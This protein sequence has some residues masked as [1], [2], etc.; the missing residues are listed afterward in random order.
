[1]LDSIALLATSSYSLSQYRRT[2]LKQYLK[3]DYQSLCTPKTKLTDQLFGDDVVNKIKSLTEG[4]KMAVMVAHKPQFSNPSS[5]RGFGGFGGFRG[6]SW[7]VEALPGEEADV[8]LGR[9]L[10]GLCQV[11]QSQGKKVVQFKSGHKYTIRNVA[12]LVGFL[13]SVCVAVPLGRLSTKVI[14]INKDSALNLNKG[15]FNAVMHLSSAALEDIDWWCVNISNS[16]APVQRG[17]PS[18]TLTTDASLVGWG[19][20]CLGLSTGGQWS[21]EELNF[22]NNINYLEL[23]ATLSLCSDISGILNRATEVKNEKFECKME[24]FQQFSMY[25]QCSVSGVN[26]Y[27]NNTE[28]MNM[29]SELCYGHVRTVSNDTNNFTHMRKR[30]LSNQDMHYLPDTDSLNKRLKKSTD[31][32]QSNTSPTIEVEPPS[33]L[34]MLIIQLSTNLNTVSEKLEKRIDELETNFEQKITEKISEKVSIMIDEKLK[35][36]IDTVRE[37]VKS[38]MSGLQNKIDE[39]E[40]TVKTKTIDGLTLS[41]ITLKSV[42]RKEGRGSYPGVVIVEI[43]NSDNKSKIMKNKRKLR[44]NRVY[45]N[46][47]INNDQPVESRNIQASIRTV[48]KELALTETF[49]QK[50][51]K[52]TFF[53]NNRKTTSRN[54]NRGSGGVGVLVKN[55]IYNS[56]TFDTLDLEFD[57]ILWIKMRSKTDFL[58]LCI[59]ICYL[60][61]SRVVQSAGPSCIFQTLLEQVYTYELNVMPDR[62]P[63]HSLLY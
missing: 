49:L 43:D 47:Y 6:F 35:Q 2:N 36:N 42:C 13:N 48:L 10:R 27:V 46:V 61:P 5:T 60:P 53:G 55:E 45:E 31:S 23:Q 58:S 62:I 28:N 33:R 57:G 26:T 51:E 38:D 7:V 17:S 50:D 9:G 29:N 52:F 21:E 30:S 14:E 59:A 20:E 3:D 18:I 56:Y 25:P 44:A 22:S 4:K 40:K 1:M 19:A 11:K 37:E 41:D 12:E 54:A 32:P 39:L 24:N 34:E 15:D 63:D 16:S 8:F